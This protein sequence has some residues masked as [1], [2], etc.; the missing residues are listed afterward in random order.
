MR[1]YE[2]PFTVSAILKEAR[3]DPN[4]FLRPRKS[5]IVEG[6]DLD[7]L[8]K[9]IAKIPTEEIRRRRYTFTVFFEECLVSADKDYGV[10]FE[11]VLLILAHYKIINDNK[12]LRYALILIQ[13]RDARRAR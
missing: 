9:I 10:S 6:V 7:I 1:I 8:N 11:S 12:S 2:E 3:P 13:I 5:R 4:A